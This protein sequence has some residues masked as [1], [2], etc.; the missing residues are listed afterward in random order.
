MGLFYHCTLLFV[1]ERAPRRD[2]IDAAPTADTNFIIVERTYRNT[3]RLY[4][5]Y[6]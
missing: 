3:G 4:F 6:V 5:R 2:F 1:V